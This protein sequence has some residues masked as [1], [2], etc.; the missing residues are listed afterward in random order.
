[1]H[2]TCCFLVAT[3]CISIHVKV[4][5]HALTFIST[6]NKCT[7]ANGKL[8]YGW[9]DIAIAS[10]LS[11]TKNLEKHNSLHLLESALVVP[12]TRRFLSTL[13]S[14]RK[15]PMRFEESAST[16]NFRTCCERVERLHIDFSDCADVF[17]SHQSSVSRPLR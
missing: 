3:L 13:S 10:L 12:S 9:F 8:I 15:Y 5:L 6:T 17:E 4:S 2:S 14:Q 11:D 16:S 7:V 1:M